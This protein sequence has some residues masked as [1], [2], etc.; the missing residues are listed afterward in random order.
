MLL[1][2]VTGTLTILSFL[3]KEDGT[4]VQKQRAILTMII[5]G[6]LLFFQLILATSKLWFPH[7]WKRN[8]SHSRHRQH[9]RHHP[10]NKDRNQPT[11]R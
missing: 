9:T 11:K 5:T 8:S 6:I 10:S 2:L 1:T 7:L 3:S 4:G